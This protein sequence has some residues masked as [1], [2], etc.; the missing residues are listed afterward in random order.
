MISAVRWEEH[1]IKQGTGYPYKTAGGMI[2]NFAN[3]FVLPTHVTSFALVHGARL[4]QQLDAQ[5]SLQKT[6]FFADM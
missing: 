2:G 5:V 1:V 3:T 6:R 4:K